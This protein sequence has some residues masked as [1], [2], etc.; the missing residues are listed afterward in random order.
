MTFKRNSRLRDKYAHRE[1]Q[2]RF[3][4]FNAI[5]GGHES[6]AQT[7]TSGIG[8]GPTLLSPYRLPKMLG[9]LI[10]ARRRIRLTLYPA[11]A[12]RTESARFVRGHRRLQR[13]FRRRCLTA[14]NR[15]RATGTAGLSG[16][17]RFAAAAGRAPG[18]EASL[19]LGDQTSIPGAR[20]ART[21]ARATRP[22]TAG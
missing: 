22:A 6:L 18:S 14:A 4:R 5:R 8:I 10:L 12:V 2:L 21:R 1:R 7:S 17:T 16:K 11:V 9:Y 15:L 20:G 19:I 13:R 3:R